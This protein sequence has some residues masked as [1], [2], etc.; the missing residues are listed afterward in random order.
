MDKELLLDYLNQGYSCREIG[1]LVNLSGKTVHYWVNKLGLN[2]YMRYK[3]P[4][5]P[6]DGIF[7]K[8]D[9]PKKAYIIGY[10]IA[11]GYITDK[12]VEYASCIADK[13]ILYF[14]QSVIGGPCVREDYTLVPAKRRYPRARYTIFNKNIVVDFNKHCSSKKEKHVPIVRKDLKK[15]LLLGYF[16]GNG[17]LTWGR[18]KDRNRLWCK[19]MF[20]GQLKSLVGI[21]KIIEEECNIP[22]VIRPKGNENAYCLEFSN[23]KNVL[24]FCEY[25][26]S[27]L[28]VLHRKYK[29]YC[30]LR[31]ELGEFGETPATPSEASDTIAC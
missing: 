21:Q 24:A 9:T 15:Y 20:V 1:R 3:K 27:D 28:I 7:N 30:A 8:I 12:C 23:R 4:Q 31:L 22:S 6:D 29:K 16:D 5:Y 25:I 14:V 11:D 13:E 18:R 19:V 26:F 10:T 17:C 2:Q